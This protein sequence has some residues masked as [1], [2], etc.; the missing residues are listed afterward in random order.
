MLVKP[1]RGTTAAQEGAQPSLPP[2]PQTQIPA[3][4]AQREGRGWQP[5][6]PWNVCVMHKDFPDMFVYNFER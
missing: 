6:S 3:H 2:P 4:T 5:L 1:H